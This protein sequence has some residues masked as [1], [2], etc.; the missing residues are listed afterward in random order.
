LDI[1]VNVP[2]AATGPDALIMGEI[3]SNVQTGRHGS[4]TYK[5]SP[6]RLT[7]KHRAAEREKPCT[8]GLSGQY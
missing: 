4:F 8:A 7:E 6:G 5:T 2:R 3:G 1:V